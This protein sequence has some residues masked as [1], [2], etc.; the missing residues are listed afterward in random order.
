[1]L[2]TFFVSCL[3]SFSSFDI[4]LFS[5]LFVAVVEFV[6]DSLFL[7]FR[8]LFFFLLSDVNKL[9]G[10]TADPSSTTPGTGSGNTESEDSAEGTTSVEAVSVG[11]SV[12]AGTSFS[13]GTSVSI[14]GCSP[15][16]VVLS[17]SF[18]SG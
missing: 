9:T 7:F 12:S 17:P 16:V 18:F 10:S 11:T 15:I 5:V 13:V 3:T 2:S 8:V 6:A 1:M 14:C 4:L